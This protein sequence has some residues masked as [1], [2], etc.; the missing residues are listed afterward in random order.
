MII[1]NWTVRL[2]MMTAVSLAAVISAEASTAEQSE[3]DRSAAHMRAH[4]RFLA[5]DLLKGREAG[6]DGYQIAAEYVASHLTQFGTSPAGENGTYFQAV[7]MVAYRPTDHGS[8]VL[9]KKSG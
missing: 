2:A 6:S 9:R 5:S 4:M 7:P 1:S 3:A 8:L